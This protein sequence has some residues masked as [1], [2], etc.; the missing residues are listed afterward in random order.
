MIA[1]KGHVKLFLDW[2]LEDDGVLSETEE[3]V[4]ERE[5]HKVEK[6]GGE[7]CDTRRLG[8]RGSRGRF[9]MGLFEG[10]M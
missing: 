6:L 8:R 2:Y 3:R 1:A 10:Q 4:A 7:A 9:A 5:G